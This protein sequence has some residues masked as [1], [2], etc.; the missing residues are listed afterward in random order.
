MLSQPSNEYEHMRAGI[1]YKVAL[2]AIRKVVRSHDELSDFD[3][4]NE[5]V[6]ICHSLEEDIRRRNSDE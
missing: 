3:K 4:V 5:I 1:E 6:K 2:Q